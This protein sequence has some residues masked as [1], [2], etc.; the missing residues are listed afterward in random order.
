MNTTVKDSSNALLEF[1]GKVSRYF[2]DFLETDFKRQ[3]VPRRRITLKDEAGQL[4]GFAVKK[5]DRL[6]RDIAKLIREPNSGLFELKISR[7]TYTAQISPILKNLI[8]QHIAGIADDDFREIRVALI[9]DATNSVTR[10]VENPEHWIEELVATFERRVATRIVHPM[11]ALLEKPLEEHAHDALESIF[12]IESEL[13]EALCKE[14]SIQ[15]GPALNTLILNGAS[16]PFEGVLEEFFDAIDAK[17]RLTDFF[18]VFAA[19]DAYQEIRELHSYAHRTGENFQLY[20]YFGDIRYRTHTFP[21]FYVPVNV[22]QAEESGGFIL[23]T[24]SRLYV[25]KAAIDWIAQE[26][27]ASGVQIAMNPIED[28]I[29]YLSEG[30]IA[31]Q[32]MDAI[33]A[34]IQNVLDLD[35]VVKISEDSVQSGK[36]SEMR[37]TSGY[38]FSAFDRSDEAL[39]NDY[40]SLL[41]DIRDNSSGVAELF[42]GVIKGMILDEP[43]SAVRG[44]DDAW[45]IEL[46]PDRLVAQTPIPLNEEQRK[47]LTAINDPKVKFLSVQGPPGT[48]KSHTITAIAFECILQGKSVLI[49]S[50]K[51]EALDVVEDKLI[52][53]IAGVRSSDSFQNPIL[54]LGKSGGTYTKLLTQT[55][56]TKI[57]THHRASRSQAAQLHADIDNAREQLRKNI[58]TKIEN[59]SGIQLA[60]LARLHEAESQTDAAWPLLASSIRAGRTT[61]VGSTQCCAANE[62][63]Q[64]EDGARTITL[65][66]EIVPAGS[67]PELLMA[68]RRIDAGASMGSLIINRAAFALFRDFDP[69]THHDYVQALIDR[70]ED[71]RFPL[72]GWTFRGSALRRLNAEAGSRLALMSHIDLHKKLSELRRVAEE[73]PKI[74]KAIL[75]HKLSEDDFSWIFGQYVHSDRSPLPECGELIGLVETAH[76]FALSI[77]AAG[78]GQIGKSPFLKAS[79]LL[80]ACFALHDYSA[81]WQETCA[82]EA[83]IPKFDFV[84][85]RSRLEQLY[86]SKMTH[87]MDGRFLNFVN[88]SSAT[89]KVL[90]KVVRSRQQFPRES[91]SKL[92]DAF[93]CII[94]GIREF[95]DYIPLERNMFDL[96]V[97]DEASQVSV[98]Q[99]FPALLR[100]KKVLVLGDARQFSNVKSANANK[101]LNNSYV[102]ELQRY[103]RENISISADKLT[104][105]TMFDVK[106]SVLDFFALI[107]NYNSMLRKHFRGYQELISFSSEHFYAGLLQ[108]IK[109]RGCPIEDVI[110]FTVIEGASSDQ[111][112]KNTNVQEAEFIRDQLDK[113]LSDKTYR[114][115]GVIT[116][117]REQ[118]TLLSKVLFASANGRDYEK[119]LR[120]KVMTFDTCQGEEREVIYYSMVA[121]IE[122]D[123]INYVLPVDIKEADDR[124][125]ETLKFQRLN[126]GFSR[127][128]E[129]IHFVLSKPIDKFAGSA[130]LVLQHYHRVLNDKSLPE[131]SAVDPSSPMEAK[132]LDWLKAAPFIQRNREAIEIQ[133]Q[134][135]IGDYL[136]Q[137]DASY[138]H[139]AYRA[140]F[141]LIYRGSGRPVNVIIEYDGFQE[142]FTNRKNVH[143]GNWAA[144]YRPEDIERQMIIESYGYKF[145][146]INRFNLGEDPVSTLSARLSELISAAEDDSD[147]SRVTQIV[148]DAN[149]LEKGEKKSCSRCGEVKLLAEFFDKN[150]KRGEGGYGR[151]CLPCKTI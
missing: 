29:L 38:Y 74:E 126:V 23:T 129:C 46:V 21:I 84:G 143:V 127:A 59:L 80:K 86:A 109:V 33:L 12:E 100:A 137:L 70:Y 88:E 20:L 116:P 122:H 48:G 130:R 87:E 85:D 83:A 61:G 7:R 132:V 27:N 68:I 72:I 31:S 57:E 81:L 44:V 135:P 112:Y 125:E 73:I 97:I 2:L 90:A 32:R 149:A 30:D 123:A 150:L 138:K 63:L 25:N 17:R 114:T 69:S 82:R 26:S 53:A 52:D 96:V 104:R 65:I 134:F 79:D 67:L 105:A 93:P 60:D 28:R 6:Y 11:L 3:N 128:Q 42:N 118:V 5:Y 14:A 140:D 136:R 40:E 36:S 115:V 99:A 139:P 45:D 22:S 92:R 89:A 66:D 13:V 76:H 111:K 62:W 120:L 147:H 94:A 16:K 19:S 102:S 58:A 151:V 113:L 49:L 18:D 39:L 142:H 64:S 145:L 119:L 50:D 56:I 131:S 51:N 108:A 133:A 103:F 55:S 10:A 110:K 8:A 71:L 41:R 35:K 9:A 124:I 75:A 144:Y 117:F 91:F 141:L 78:I 47:I 121:T 101:S 98:A 43:I 77:D 37:V 34:R 54:R 4:T 107:S 95:A 15:F 148:E 146:R 24:D 1:G 106:K